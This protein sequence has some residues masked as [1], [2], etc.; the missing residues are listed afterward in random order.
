MIKNRLFWKI[1]ASIWVS[2]ALT[3]AG[4]TVALIIH[5][6]SRFEQATHVA[7]NPRAGIINRLVATSIEIGG[8]AQVRQLLERWPMRQNG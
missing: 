5:N 4:I 7:Q 6:Q 2:L 1:Y 8:E 3:A